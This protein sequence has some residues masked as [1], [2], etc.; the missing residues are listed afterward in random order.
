MLNKQVLNI[1][2]CPSCKKR[3][4]H[5]KYNMIFICHDCNLKFNINQKIPQMIIDEAQHSN[6]DKLAK[7]KHI[8]YK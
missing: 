8:L 4:K 5:D 2:A 6:V 7:M 3:V 1:M